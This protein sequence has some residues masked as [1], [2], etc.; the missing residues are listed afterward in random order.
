[1]WVGGLGGGITPPEACGSRR[2]H[3]HL[4]KA[5]SG[6]ARAKEPMVQACAR[7]GVKA[8]TARPTRR[9]NSEEISPRLTYPSL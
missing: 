5:G 4:N 8:E 9:S 1:M 2:L 7:N 6:S 3:G